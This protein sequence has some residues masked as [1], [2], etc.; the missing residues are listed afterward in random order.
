ME[1]VQ[2]VLRERY[3]EIRYRLD[4]SKLG[5]QILWM[6]YLTLLEHEKF[7]SLSKFDEEAKRIL[8]E[9]IKNNNPDDSLLILYV[10]QKDPPYKNYLALQEK[11]REYE[12]K[13]N[14]EKVKSD[15]NKITEI[16]V[17]E[18]Y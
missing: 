14:V 18:R 1:I 5:L 4:K 8:E 7:G 3:S 9:R 6:Q 12:R 13:A 11:I 2:N 17:F 10:L 15:L 16:V